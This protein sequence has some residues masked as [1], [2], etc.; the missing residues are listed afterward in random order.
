MSVYII[1]EILSDIRRQPGI[2]F[3][4]FDNTLAK[5]EYMSLRMEPKATAA[6]ST[7]QYVETAASVFDILAM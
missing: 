2:L 4:K 7:A 3:W 5:C 6:I 1:R